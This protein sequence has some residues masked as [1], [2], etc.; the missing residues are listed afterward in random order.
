MQPSLKNWRRLQKRLGYTFKDRDLLMRSLTH[1]SYLQEDPE[2][3]PSNQRMEFL[4]DSVL[5]L[6]LTEALFGQ[7]PEEREGVLSKR[8][9]SLTKG[10]F[11]TQ[12]ALDLGLDAVLRMSTSEIE[13]GGQQRP[14]SLEDALE[15]L[16]AAIFL[17]S[18]FPTA[19]RTVLAWYGDLSERISGLAS[20]DNPKGRLQELVQPVHG[21]QAL[22]YRVSETRGEPHQREFSVQLFLNQNLIGE[23]R[24]SSK[25]E[26][27]ESAARAAL[28]SWNED[29]PR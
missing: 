4:G 26:A 21:N 11:L 16:I 6:V 25:K 20:A 8:R 19:R 28:S 10:S 18:D 15:A 1:P 9:A 13:S 2:A 29:G 14:S 5:Q 7:F 12:M 17:D 3:G 24:G 27:E 23:G 22:A